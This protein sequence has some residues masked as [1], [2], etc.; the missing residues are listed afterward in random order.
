M[1]G[2]QAGFLDKVRT[3]FAASARLRFHLAPPLLSRGVDSRGRPRKREFG[4]WI[5]P[6]FRLLASL[7]GLRG[8]RLDVFGMTA[9][10]KMER[11]L[12]NEF[13]EQ[14]HVILDN[15]TIDNVDLAVEIMAEYL[16]IR[17]YGPVKEKA[18]AAAREKISSKLNA[19]AGSAEKAA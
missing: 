11:A 7:K 19:F 15:L 17:G 12:I 2:T 5:I 9:E 3:D 8:T 18:A 13:E 16:E 6:L 10:R 14:V 1:R 4:A